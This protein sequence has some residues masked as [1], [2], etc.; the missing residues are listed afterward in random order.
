MEALLR[1]TK[2][3][4][5]AEFHQDLERV[6]SHV[7]TQVGTRSCWLSADCLVR[8]LPKTSAALAEAVVE[9]LLASEE[10]HAA[11][12]E[13]E[14]DLI[15][16]RDDDDAVADLFLRRALYA[17]SPYARSPVGETGEVS[18]ATDL[19]SM[20]RRHFRRGNMVLGLAGDVGH[21]D[22]EGIAAHLLP[23]LAPA[24]VD[25]EPPLPSTLDPVL[26]V[27]DKPERS[28]TQLRLARVAAEPGSLPLWLGTLAFGGTFS[29]PLT[30][31]VRERRG[32][33][34]GADA[35]FDHRQAAPAPI[36]LAAAPAA[37]YGW[38]CAELMLDLAQ[39]WCEH[40]P[41][42]EAL[43]H[44][45]R[46]SQ[47]RLPFL[48]TSARDLLTTA[49]RDV[50]IGRPADHVR[51][52]GARIEAIDETAIRRSLGQDHGAWR[53]VVVGPAPRAFRGWQIR[54]ASYLE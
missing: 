4:T 40:G 41:G 47:N 50:L 51:S 24:A 39:Q 34:Y 26:W 44:A 42:A 43:A 31:E 5:R 30:A 32:W 23:R 13:V 38:D 12:A 11:Q 22:L 14:A 28:Q 45:K 33:S 48:F 19:G 7:S 53:G 21:D 54:P 2:A 37:E 18:A 36:V 35:T 46:Y 15:A 1:G 52:L 27:V 8:G 9:P 10:I 16:A 20:H 25:E 17:G 29:A 3:R 6:G 49:L